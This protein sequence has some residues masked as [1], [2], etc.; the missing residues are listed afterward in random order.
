[1]YAYLCVFHIDVE[2]CKGQERTLGPME[3]KLQVTASPPLG[4]GT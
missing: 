1:M 4:A 2:A 3:L